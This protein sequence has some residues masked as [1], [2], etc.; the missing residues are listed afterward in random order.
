MIND[1]AGKLIADK[2]RV[3]NLIRESESGD[4]YLGRHEVIDKPVLLKILPAAFAVDQR[5]VKRF[6]GE[7]R[8]SSTLAH[9]GILNVT[10]FGT[11]S[12]GVS[13]AVFEHI[14]G[15]TL[16]ELNASGE[17]LDEKRAI[18]FA[19]QIA[20]AITTAHSKNI[21]HGRLE[22]KNILVGE[23]D[24]VKVYGFGS[25]PLTVPR[26]ADPRFLAPE[27]CNAFPAADERSDVYSL[28]VLVF[29]M[30]GGVV[31]FEGS[32]AAD[33]LVRQN[34]EPPPPLS[35]FS[36]D[37]HPEIEPIVLSAM[38][39]D[40]DRRYPNMAAFAE[41]L[42]ILAGRLGT[43]TSATAAAA[44]A[45]NT[46]PKRNAWQTAIFAF[47]GIAIFAGALIYAT[48]VRQT[49]PTETVQAESGSLPVQPI[50]P[51]TGAQEESLARLPALTDAEIMATTAQGDD[52][53]G[54]DGL[55]PWAN[56]A[57]PPAGAPLAGSMP[58]MPSGGGL[59]PPVGYVPPGGQEYTVGDGQSPFMPPSSGGVEI[60]NYTINP[61]TGQCIKIPSGEVFPCPGSKAPA[62]AAPTPNT[63]AANTSAQP[64]PEPTPATT[65]PKPM[66]T[67]PP[68][69][70]PGETEKKPATAK[71]KSGTEKK[72]D[73]LPSD[74]N[75]EL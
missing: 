16:D 42:Q 55:D 50:G 41:D 19:R 58:G 8:T 57:M 70:K 32:T 59:V 37:L 46:G 75:S 22:P 38:A 5:W 74:E 12:K 40:P 7:A 47:V 68:K 43:P 13:Y 27:Q 1:V 71:P 9:P 63:P 15:V 23:G 28:G 53:P 51:A 39:L 52:M 35:A 2:Y 20:S 21:V 67:P 48:S 45:G 66:A 69:T 26:D 64:T 25:D 33:I 24:S 49:D 18:D 4:L 14:D 31:P 61:A 73:E 17:P 10:D 11:D 30:L 62:K 3:E 36:R 6:I 65:G 60:I 72:T 56:G 54:G 44:A 29:Q 34:S